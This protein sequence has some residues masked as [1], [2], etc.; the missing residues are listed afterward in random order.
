MRMVVAKHG[1]RE[2]VEFPLSREADEYELTK[3][4]QIDLLLRKQ[5][6]AAADGFRPEETAGRREL[7]NRLVIH[8]AQFEI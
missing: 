6:V 5:R 3:T 8:E 4:N 7:R 2:T 1:N